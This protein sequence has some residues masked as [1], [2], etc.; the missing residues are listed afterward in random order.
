[1][2]VLIFADQVGPTG[3]THSALLRILEIHQEERIETALLV[4]PRAIEKTLERQCEA[5][6]VTL[7]S[8]PDRPWAYRGMFW[9]YTKLLR[10]IREFQ[11]DLLIVSN[12]VP[13]RGFGS[14]LFSIPVLFFMHTYPVTR[15]CVPWVPALL[16]GSRKRIVTVSQYAS[17]Q[18]QYKMK[19]PGRLVEVVSNGF[20]PPHEGKDVSRDRDLVLTV[21]HV[22]GYKNPDVWL[23]V[24]ERVIE[25]RSGTRFVW[26]GDGERLE[27][28]RCEIEIRGL[29]DSV[30]LPGH[31]SAVGDAYERTSVYF[32]PSLRE[33]QGI[34][35]IDAM[36]HGV[37]C[38]ASSVGGIPESVEDGRT[39]YLCDPRD[40]AGFAERIL[41]CLEDPVLAAR[42]GHAG[43]ERAWQHFSPVRHRERYLELVNEIAGVS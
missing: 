22:V 26:L 8:C 18:I 37:P 29:G 21:G 27:Q 20:V 5:S 6:G 42:L 30:K 23:D 40:V 28:L 7:Y 35:L 38:V 33:S 32:H 19:A 1:M 15:R 12:Q 14:F 34:A 17:R 4:P 10:P 43:R 3:G 31:S 36:A 9:E 25:H 2:R 39:G 11:P 24:V 41:S 16:T 13:G